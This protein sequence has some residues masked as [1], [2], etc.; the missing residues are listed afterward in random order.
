VTTFE[1]QR[2]TARLNRIAVDEENNKNDDEE[3]FKFVGVYIGE[4]PSSHHTNTV[5]GQ[6]IKMK[7][8]T[9]NTPTAS[10]P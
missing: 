7:E 3:K 4:S 10:P 6:A 1:E 9:F 8:A 2:R 5:D